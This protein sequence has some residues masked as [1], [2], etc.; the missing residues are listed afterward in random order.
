[1]SNDKD[2]KTVTLEKVQQVFSQQEIQALTQQQ[3]STLSTML[4]RAMDERGMDLTVDELE[5]LKELLYDHLT[6]PGA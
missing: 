5:G 6:I 2:L 1:M 3:R 4:A